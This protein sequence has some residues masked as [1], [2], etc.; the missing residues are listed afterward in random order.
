[1][2]LGRIAGCSPEVPATWKEI[3]I[4]GLTYELSERE[5][6]SCLDSGILTSYYDEDLGRYC[7]LKGVNTL[8]NNKLQMNPDG[9][10]PSI[11]IKRIEFQLNKELVLDCK[12]ELASQR[13]GV[14]ILTISEEFLTDW[15]IEKLKQKIKRGLIVDYDEVKVQRQGD[16]Y[17]T[18]Y[19]FKPD[20]EINFFFFTG[21]LIES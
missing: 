8:Q 14:N 13:N 18:S 15:T 12:T 3:D 9:T 1:L 6:E 17:F 5:L 21:V 19:K 20:E 10:T 11:Q 16:A 7:I 2:V 4:L